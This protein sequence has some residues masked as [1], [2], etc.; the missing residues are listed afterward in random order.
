MLWEEVSFAHQYKLKSER[1]P[2]FNSGVLMVLTA[3]C[4]SELALIYLLWIKKI[5]GRFAT[6]LDVA[7]SYR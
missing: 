2:E 7:F 1:W 5:S 6:K 4:V 3:L